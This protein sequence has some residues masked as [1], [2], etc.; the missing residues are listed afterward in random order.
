MLETDKANAGEAPQSAPQGETF[1]KSEALE[2][3]ATCI[4]ESG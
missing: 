3:M 4:C 1:E 2:L